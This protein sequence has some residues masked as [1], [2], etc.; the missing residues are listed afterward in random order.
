G[1]NA[2]QCAKNLRQQELQDLRQQ[3][4]QD[5]R[6]QELQDLRQQELRAQTADPANEIPGHAE[7]AGEIRRR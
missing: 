2:I 6:Q 1:Q 5:L 4:L 7:R 3:E